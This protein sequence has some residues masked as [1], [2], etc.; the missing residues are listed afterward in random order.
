MLV[1]SHQSR[2]VSPRVACAVSSFITAA[3]VTKNQYLSPSKFLLARPFNLDCY[4]YDVGGNPGA[5]RGGPPK[6]RKTEK[7]CRQVPVDSPG[8]FKSPARRCRRETP[9]LVAALV[10]LMRTT[11]SHILYIARRTL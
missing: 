6:T 10:D 8:G 11:A 1:L 3:S 5:R 2:A 7:N 4:T 9:L